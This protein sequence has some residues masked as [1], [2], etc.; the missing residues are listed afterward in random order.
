MLSLCQKLLDYEE[1]EVFG[2]LS[3]TNIDSVTAYAC[4]H[5]NKSLN[6]KSAVQT[7]RFIDVV[8]FKLF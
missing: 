5:L 6:E 3:F 8:S 2:E 1:M 4:L 7:H